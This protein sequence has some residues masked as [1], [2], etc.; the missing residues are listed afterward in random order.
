VITINSKLIRV[1]KIPC[2]HLA[3]AFDENKNTINA[4]LNKAKK[5]PEEAGKELLW[6]NDYVGADVFGIFKN[7]QFNNIR[8]KMENER[9]YRRRDIYHNCERVGG[10]VEI[11][12]AGNSL[13]Q[14]LSDHSELKKQCRIKKEKLTEVLQQNENSSY[15]RQPH[16]VAYKKHFGNIPKNFHIHHIDNDHDN[17]LPENIVA[18]PRIFHNC[19][20][21]NYNF[22]FGIAKAKLITKEILLDVLDFYKQNNYT[23]SRAFSTV[24]V[25][26]LMSKAGKV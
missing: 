23:F 7:S 25:E 17:N 9:N 22:Y 2:W 3:K 15:N 18:I 13:A 20:H 5:F 14:S 21:E 11:T 12:N 19:I 26:Y 1:N 10:L 8:N 24:F 4:I 6:L 16:I